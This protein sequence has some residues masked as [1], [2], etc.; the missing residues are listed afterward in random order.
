M[1]FTKHG[2]G[3]SLASLSNHDQFQELSHNKTGNK[4]YKLGSHLLTYYINNVHG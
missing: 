1:L 4:F 3:H 2:S